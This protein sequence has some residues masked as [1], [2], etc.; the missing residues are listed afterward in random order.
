MSKRTNVLNNHNNN[1]SNKMNNNI[2]T[3]NIE[4]ETNELQYIVKRNG[5]RVSEEIHLTYEEAKQEFD[6]WTEIIKR[7]PD[8]SK[9]EI[10]SL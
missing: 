4:T 5:I 3:E 9:L 1:H 2:I 10:V 6:Y 7:W 8:G